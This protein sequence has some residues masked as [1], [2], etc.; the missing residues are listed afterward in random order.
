M[1]TITGTDNGETLPGTSGDDQIFGLGG[2][3]LL[4]GGAG[5]D[6]T[7]GG[8]GNDQHVVESPG[9]VVVER[10][11]EGD[12]TVIASVSYALGDGT[13]VETLHTDNAAST[14]PLALWGNEIAQSIYGNAGNNIPT[15]GG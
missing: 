10:P 9:D 11:G 2:N 15:A 13:W 12:D 8:E 7:D 5:N 14:A 1:P 6:T 3:D 4:I